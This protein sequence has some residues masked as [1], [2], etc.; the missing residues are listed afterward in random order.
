MT[1]S[2]GPS[3]SSADSPQRGATP[4][5]SARFSDASEG[6]AEKPSEF[7]APPEGS[8]PGP[9]DRLVGLAVWVGGAILLIPVVVYVAVALIRNRLMSG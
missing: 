5:D 4:P 1:K 8:D 6:S 7:Y 9:S 2:A 3:S